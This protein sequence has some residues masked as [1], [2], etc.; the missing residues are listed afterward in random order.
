VDRFEKARVFCWNRKPLKVKVL[1]TML[2]YSG[3][4]YRVVARVLRELARFTHES[5]AS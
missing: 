3:L 1:S 5:V 4:S 2:Y